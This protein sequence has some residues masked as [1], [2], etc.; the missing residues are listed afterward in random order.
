[1]LKA[2]III[3]MMASRIDRNG[4]TV[5][6]YGY[7]SNAENVY[8]ILEY[9]PGVSLSELLD[10][11][12]KLSPQR[13]ARVINSLCKTINSYHSNSKC[14]I[15]HRD[16]K[17]E[18]V[19]W[20]PNH[21][22][23]KI[24]DFG[25]AFAGDHCQS[26]ICTLKYA[27]PEIVAQSSHGKA[28]GIYALGVLL[29]QLLTGKLPF[30]SPNDKKLMEMIIEGT[31]ECWYDICSDGKDLITKVMKKNPIVRINLKRLKE[32]PFITNNTCKWE[33]NW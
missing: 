24:A 7:F 31:I 5:G 1:M 15:I 22:E 23:G 16:M 11:E 25:V 14:S 9:V 19:L 32:H 3:Q 2:E 17:P 28:V 26:K 4:N 18:N 13:A 12:E 20:V 29:F 30:E 21:D 8:L 10:N 33:R 6:I 27:A